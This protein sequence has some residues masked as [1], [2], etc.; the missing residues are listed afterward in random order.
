MFYKPKSLPGFL[1]EAWRMWGSSRL[2]YDSWGETDDF[3]N[4]LKKPKKNA[5]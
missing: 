2:F 3:L 5:S 4:G 1:D